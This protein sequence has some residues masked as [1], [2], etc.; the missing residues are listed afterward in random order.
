M[1]GMRWWEMRDERWEMRDNDGHRFSEVSTRWH[2]FSLT[3]NLSSVK[4]WVRFTKIT[5][6]LRNSATHRFV[7]DS[8]CLI[9]KK[10]QGRVN[11]IWFQLA[12]RYISLMADSSIHLFLIQIDLSVTWGL[13]VG[14]KWLILSPYLFSLVN[15]LEGAIQRVF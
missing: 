3:G 9:N 1:K 5:D 6:T 11:T 7:P 12:V 2:S 13:P 8:I 4:A 10:E 14:Y 15:E